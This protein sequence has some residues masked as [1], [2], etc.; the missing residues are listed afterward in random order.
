[1]SAGQVA[2]AAS[3]A[4]SVFDKY[5]REQIEILK[6]NVAPPNMSDAQLAYCLTVARSR[7]LDPFKKQ[8]YFALRNKKSRGPRGE[9]IY[10]S[11]V[12]VEPTIDGFRSM[13]EQTGELDGY[14][15]PFW[16]GPDGVWADVW[17]DPKQPPVAAK[18]T[19][20]RKGRNRGTTAVARYDAY[21]Q[22]G[23]VWQKMGDS[24]LAKCA[25]SLALRKAFPSE[26]GEFYTHEEMA[27]ASQQGYQFGSLPPEPTKLEQARVVHIAAQTKVAPREQQSDGLSESWD[28]TKPIPA[29]LQLW[30]KPLQKVGDRALGELSIDELEM[31]MEQCATAFSRAEQNP[32]S[33]RRQLD[34]IN[35]IGAAANDLVNATRGE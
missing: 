13:A 21:K 4:M 25:E 33:T 2:V 19:V 1:M 8:V 34:L 3:E 27:Q 23:P 5:S 29:A 31:V 9:D 26:L 20:F 17:L 11:A 18:I 6:T 35:E 14:E 24:M 15:G 30:W 12:T 16:C 7:N 32:K 10:V 28:I 22:E